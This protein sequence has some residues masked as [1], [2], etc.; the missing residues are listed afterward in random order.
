[1][2]N[3]F[4]QFDSQKTALTNEGQPQS[5]PVNFFDQFDPKTGV[6]TELESGNW[7]NLDSVQGAGLVLEGMTL[8]WSDKLLQL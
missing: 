4:D 8:G 6:E 1:M 5:K 7:T 2:A 3:F